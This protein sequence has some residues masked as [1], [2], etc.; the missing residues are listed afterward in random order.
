MSIWGG[1]WFYKGK[2][3]AYKY[4]G[5]MMSIKG[6]IKWLGFSRKLFNTEKEAALYVDRKLIAMKKE[7]VNILK[8]VAV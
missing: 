1:R 2:S 6:E 5:K 7:P 8:R 4:V 3:K